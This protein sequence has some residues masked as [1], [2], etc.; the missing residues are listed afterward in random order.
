MLK[1]VLC[2]WIILLCVHNASL[3]NELYNNKGIHLPFAQLGIL[4]LD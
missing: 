3:N 2:I 1:Y 4:A